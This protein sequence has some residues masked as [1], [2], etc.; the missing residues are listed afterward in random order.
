MEQTN[1]SI[2]T[3]PHSKRNFKPSHIITLG[4]AIAI[5]LG[6]VV[7][8]D[9]N[10]LKSFSLGDQKI[11]IH[12]PHSGPRTEKKENSDNTH[13]TRIDELHQAS[14]PEL[15]KSC[16]KE[17]DRNE[18]LHGVI[19]AQKDTIHHLKDSISTGNYKYE[20]LRS[21]YEALKSQIK[22]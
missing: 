9:G 5:F 13:T 17:R 7:N 11:N 14:N 16:E 21:K 19:Y 8:I 4:V 20:A 12:E 15:I 1:H 6:I 2:N 18:K 10:V 22:G 3:D